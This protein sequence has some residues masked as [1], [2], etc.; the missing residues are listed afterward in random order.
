L[1]SL[2]TSP[3]PAM[4]DFFLTRLL[5]YITKFKVSYDRAFNIVSKRYK[6]PKWLYNMFYK[7]GYYIVLNYYGLRWLAARKGFGKR[8]IAMI[9]YFRSIGYSVRRLEHLLEK[10]VEGLTTIKRLSIRYSYPEYIIRDLMGRLESID[11]LEQY[12]RKLNERKTWLRVNLLKGSINDAIPCL[13]RN[14]VD[15]ERDSKLGYMLYVRRPLWIKPGKLDCF[16][17]GLVIPQD[18]ASAYVVEVFNKLEGDGVYLDTCSA[19]GVKL[20]LLFMLDNSIYMVVAVDKSWK[21]LNSLKKLARLQNIP[22]YKLSIIHGDSASLAYPRIFTKA[23]VDAPCSGSGSIPSD[24][25]VKIALARKN[26]LYYYTELQKKI[27]ANTLRYAKRVVYAV[28]SIHPAEGE[29]VI[30]YFVNKGVAEPVEV[31]IKLPKAYHGYRV[32]D[33]TYRTYPHR[34]RSQGFYIAVLERKRAL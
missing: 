14:Y 11:E 19:P 17:K 12:L 5:D 27:L 32:S 34:N 21:R 25:G 3:P 18:I 20:G 10:E 16:H 33:K 29:E 15:I 22:G 24:P 31:D 7:I 28:C 6:P 30:E 4:T 8:P 23:L 9:T 1:I 13:K 26:K 2:E